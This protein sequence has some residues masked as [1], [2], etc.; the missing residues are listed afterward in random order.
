MRTGFTGVK[1]VTAAAILLSGCLLLYHMQGGTLGY[2]IPVPSP[3]LVLASLAFVAAV[4]AAWGSSAQPQGAWVLGLVMVGTQFVLLIATGIALEATEPKAP[5]AQL[6]A[7]LTNG[8]TCVIAAVLA[9][10][11][12]I[13]LHSAL[14][15]RRS[16]R[17][18]RAM[19][20]RSSVAAQRRTD[21]EADSQPPDRGF[22]LG[23][24]GVES[25]GA[26]AA[27]RSET[28]GAG[29][30]APVT[31]AVECEVEIPLAPMLGQLSQLGAV[32]QA[33]SA[34]IQPD[35]S[36]KIPASVVAPGLRE[37]EVALPMSVLAPYLPVDMPHE[38]APE[39]V[40]EM[41]AQPM[42]LLPLEMIVS[43]IP[44]EAFALPERVP[45]E[46]MSLE[47][48]GPEGGFVLS[49]LSGTQE[50]DTDGVG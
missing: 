38:V 28:S 47:P 20:A 46:W 45:P 11:T 30:P 29:G 24:P 27:D 6:V 41:M 44:E 15:G 25:A 37:G 50:S 17:R 12:W 19:R 16:H 36:I 5:G 31:L 39:E 18:T 10:A 1:V 3:W 32:D 9:V 42:I 40:G 33:A 49:R 7:P 43:Q 22:V 8:T 14:G 21:V 23:V 35:L 2:S 4:A 48:T 13:P 26:L 34:R